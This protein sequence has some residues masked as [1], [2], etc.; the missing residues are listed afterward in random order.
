MNSFLEQFKQSCF[1]NKIDYW[2]VDSSAPMDQV[3]IKFLVRRESS[4]RLVNKA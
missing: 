3:L 2:L 4:R 1:E